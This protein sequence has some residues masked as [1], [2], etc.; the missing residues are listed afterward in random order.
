MKKILIGLAGA[1]IATMS[2]MAFAQTG[3]D[4]S[5]IV[6]IM[7]TANMGEVKAAKAAQGKASSPE[8]RK[9]AQMMIADHQNALNETAPVAK[10]A[11]IKPLPNMHS[12]NLKKENRMAMRKM[13]KL[14]GNA[15]DQA[16]MDSQISM[17]QN[18][19]GLIDTALLPNAKNPELK[20]LLSKQRTVIDGHL[21]QA[22]QIRTTL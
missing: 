7:N 14:Q 4:D 16:Y 8:V 11:K 22:R 6:S 2:S 18:V 10:K 19:L 13:K 1:L 21:Q 5:E 15:F 12:R 20:A 17:H 3:V 9:F